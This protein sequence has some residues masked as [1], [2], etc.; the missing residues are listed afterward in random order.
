[1][2]EDM[3]RFIV[4]G[5]AMTTQ[6]LLKIWTRA[7][8]GAVAVAHCANRSHVHGYLPTALKSATVWPMRGR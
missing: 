5:S 8:L 1:M 3:T 6:C 4:D 2:L 7:G